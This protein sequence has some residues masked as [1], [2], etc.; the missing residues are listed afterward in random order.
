MSADSFPLLRLIE[1]VSVVLYTALALGSLIFRNAEIFFGVLAG[2]AFV[3]LNFRLLRLIAQ[4][5]FKDPEKPRP[6]YF[7]LLVPKFTVIGVVLW[8][9]VNYRWFDIIAFAV[10]TLCLFLAI[11]GVAFIRGTGPVPTMPNGDGTK[12]E[13]AL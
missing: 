4:A 7:L 8:L 13:T 11:I 6:G 1:K 2:G 12:D 9:V 10:G 3:M 5:V